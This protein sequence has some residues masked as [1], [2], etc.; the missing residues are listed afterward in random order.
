MPLRFL[1]LGSNVLPV[2]AHLDIVVIRLRNCL[3]HIHLDGSE[4]HIGAGVSCA[5]VAKLLLQQGHQDAVFFAGIPGTVGGAIRMNA[6][7]FGGETWRYCVGIDCLD[8]KGKKVRVLPD[9]LSIGYS[10][11]SLPTDWCIIQG[12]FVFPHNPGPKDKI[13]TLLKTRASSQPIGLRSCGSV[14]KNPE[15]HYAAQLIDA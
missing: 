6:G 15:G 2:D 7:A 11:I 1:G 12:R 5:K 9:E 3:Q 14:F 8:D 10:H 13:A 4:V